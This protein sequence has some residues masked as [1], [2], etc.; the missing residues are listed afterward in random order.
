MITKIGS[1]NLLFDGLPLLLDRSGCLPM[2][3]ARP[4]AEVTAAALPSQ[5]PATGTNPVDRTWP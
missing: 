2:R 1:V 5:A 4:I 3:L